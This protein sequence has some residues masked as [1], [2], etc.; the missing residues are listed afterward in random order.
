MRIAQVAPLIE[1]VPPRL[2]GGTERGAAWLTE[3]LVEA[4]HEVGL[5]ASGDSKTA[6]RLVAC[7]PQGLRLSGIRDHT[8]S[9]LAMLEQVLR[10]EAEF[11]VI[12]FHT[13]LLQFALFQGLEHK[14]V[15]T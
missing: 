3:S 11:D 15:S 10:R 5:F 1:A 13:D 2:Y 14:C 7:S 9:H 12:H 8:A 6:A 4:G